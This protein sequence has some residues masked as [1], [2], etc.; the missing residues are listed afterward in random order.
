MQGVRATPVTLN[1]MSTVTDEI[2]VMTCIGSQIVTCTGG[3]DAVVY[4]F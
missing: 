4:L 3:N 1:V 2:Y